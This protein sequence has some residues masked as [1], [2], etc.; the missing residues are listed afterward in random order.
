MPDIV[1]SIIELTNRVKAL[2]R[3]EEKYSPLGQVLAARLAQPGLVGFWP[4]SSIDRSS[5]DIYDVSGQGR[6]LTYTGTPTYSYLASGIPYFQ[7][8]GTGD[9]ATRA[10][11]ADLQITGGETIYDSTVR[12]MTM[13]LW[14]KIDSWTNS[15]K[16]L[17]G[18]WNETGNQRSFTIALSSAT[19]RLDAFVSSN[20]TATTSVISADITTGTWYHA[21][22]VYVPSTSLSIIVNGITKTTNTTSIPATIFAST[23]AFRLG[24]AELLATVS[25]GLVGKRTLASPPFF[26]YTKE[27]P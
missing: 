18:K 25:V 24:Q 5:G 17:M 20:G 22:V 21:A 2:E 16:Q 19:P 10:S 26:R 27:I 8:N 23:A 11:E 12:G 6:T 1:S 7:T 9:Y 4:T 14:F 13:M 15:Y 3:K